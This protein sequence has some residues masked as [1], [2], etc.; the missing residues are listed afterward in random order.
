MAGEELENLS[1]AVV[2]GD[3]EKILDLTNAALSNGISADDILKKGLIP[4]IRKVGELFNK[5]EYFL[6]ELIVS[7][8]AVQTAVDYLS[9]KFSKGKAS[10]SGKFLIGTVKGDVHDIGKNIVK[11]MFKSNGWEVTDLGVD[12]SPEQFCTA[13]REGDFD[14]C[15]MSALLTM[16][17][18]QAAEAIK[19]L[20]NAGLR[21]KV[22]IMIGGAPVTQ[23]YA[24]QI[25]ADAYGRDAWDALTKAEGLLKQK[26]N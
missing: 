23:E 13:I 17:M 16:T 3:E 11:M 4:G 26:Q 12:I 18:A 24:K 25:G 19:A 10:G 14:I 21:D 9:P 5:G 1:K 2:E 6:P 7:G 22:K 8:K 15:G 20:K